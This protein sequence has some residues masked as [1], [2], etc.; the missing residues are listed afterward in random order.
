MSPAAAALKLL[1][2]RC[3]GGGG[4]GGGG[5]GDGDGG[6]DGDLGHCVRRD[7]VWVQDVPPGVPR[8]Q[9]EREILA[10][11]PGAA[12]ARPWRRSSATAYVVGFRSEA[13][14]ARALAER[15]FSLA[16]AGAP[17]HASLAVHDHMHC[18]FF[19]D[20]ASF[21]RLH[22]DV[23][24]ADLPAIFREAARAAGAERVFGARAGAASA[25][26]VVKLTSR[27]AARAA[28]RA[29]AAALPAALGRPCWPM[30][31]G[32]LRV[33]PQA[34]P[35]PPP[36]CDGV[37][38]SRDMAERIGN[39]LHGVREALRCALT[40]EVMREPCVLLGDGAC[41]DAAAVRA[42]LGAPGE[43]GGGLGAAAVPCA[44]L[45][46]VADA[47]AAAGLV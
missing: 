19:R 18:E 1:P 39:A 20:R 4:G 8:A 24:R 34:A 25:A 35:P 17:V 40:G 46:A 44:A 36:P 47:M 45:R 31:P 28:A 21:V 22:G 33:G 11:L 26:V 3:D 38:L 6:G 2:W 16:V 29:L 30:G 5:D 41:V 23:G 14:A 37:L 9:A 15:R 7:A 12:W 10:S 43:G 27:A 32:D 13:D 42:A